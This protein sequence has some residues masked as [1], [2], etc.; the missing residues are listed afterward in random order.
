[1]ERPYPRPIAKVSTDQPVSEPEPLPNTLAVL[2][3]CAVDDAS[4]LDASTYIPYSGNWHTS[5]RRYPCEV[6]LAGCIMAATLSNPPTRTLIPD[7]FSADTEQKL[8]IVDSM[9]CGNWRAAFTCLYQQDPTAEI[10]R[11]LFHIPTPR[12]CHFYG[13]AEFET[14]LRS[15]TNLLPRL[16]KIDTLAEE[17]GF[18]SFSLDC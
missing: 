10:N 2:L 11:E 8:G 7:M 12:L 15:L 14:H 18:T 9:R 17:A 4:T 3:K 16:Q 6:C 1:M 5:R 13:W